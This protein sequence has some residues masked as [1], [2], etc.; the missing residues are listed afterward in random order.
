MIASIQRTPGDSRRERVKIERQ[1][2]VTE[3]EGRGEERESGRVGWDGMAWAGREDRLQDTQANRLGRRC[4]SELCLFCAS[5]IN[6]FYDNMCSRG[7]NRLFDPGFRD[8]VID[9]FK[10]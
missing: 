8:K 2:R 5:I 10:F 7:A 9:K 4:T 3:G 1:E 6:Y